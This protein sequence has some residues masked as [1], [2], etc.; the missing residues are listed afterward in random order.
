MWGKKNTEAMS[1]LDATAESE[2]AC[3]G[4]SLEVKG[5]ITAP[6]TC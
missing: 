4:R 2:T 5:E 1:P 6:R 3:L